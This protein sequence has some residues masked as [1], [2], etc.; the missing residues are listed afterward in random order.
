MTEDSLEAALVLALNLPCHVAQEALQHIDAREVV[1]KSCVLRFALLK[2]VI[3]VE[4]RFQGD[5]LLV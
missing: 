4:Y 2:E 5:V 3:L 1:D